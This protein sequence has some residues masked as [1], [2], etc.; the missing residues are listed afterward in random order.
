VHLVRANFYDDKAILYIID[1][2]GENLLLHLIKDKPNHLV[3]RKWVEQALWNLDLQKRFG[4]EF[5]SMEYQLANFLRADFPELFSTDE[6][7]E[8]TIEFVK[9]HC[10]RCQ[11]ANLD[12]PFTEQIVAGY[13]FSKFRKLVQLVEQ[14][15]KS[16]GL[17]PFL[18][19]K[20]AFSILTEKF[21]EQIQQ[22]FEKHDFDYNNEHAHDFGDAKEAALDDHLLPVVL[23]ALKQPRVQSKI[24][25]FTN[26]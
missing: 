6:K 21:G 1:T 8:E 2:L 15:T 16:Q 19:E 14:A 23:E 20:I 26:L 25:F 11:N 12:N 24:D 4:T 9:E 10:E 22:V 3:F 13:K 18:I 7:Y 17:H 5:E